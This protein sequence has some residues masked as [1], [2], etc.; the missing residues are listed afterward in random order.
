MGDKL[1]KMVIKKNSLL[2]ALIFFSFALNSN[3]MKNT[4]SLNK[5]HAS[6]FND[7]FIIYFDGTP[8]KFSLKKITIEKPKEKILKK[9]K[10]LTDED[11]YAVKVFGKGNKYLYT[12]GLGNPFYAT[13]QH[14]GFED[15][16]YMGG[17]V[18]SAK[19]EIAIPLHIEPTSLVISKRNQ[20]GKLTDIQTI[21]IP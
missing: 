20:A 19:V 15:R 4:L 8:S 13:Y 2:V 9:I 18:N 11:T 10:F 7:A 3:D 21:T 16:K 5:L 14:I 12:I 6:P 1:G 17:L